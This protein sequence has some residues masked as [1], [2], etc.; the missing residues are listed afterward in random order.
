VRGA[1]FL[2]VLAAC[3]PDETN[4]AFLCGGDAD[5][6][7]GQAC[8]GGRCRRG[9]GGDGVLCMTET[10]DADHMCCI[11]GINAPRC[12]PAGDACAGDAAMC[13][14]V[15]DCT[16]GDRCCIDHITRC[17][18]SCAGDVACLSAADCPSALPNCCP[19]DLPWG[20]CFESPC[21]I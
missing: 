20:T 16:A 21:N 9:D 13:D 1:V 17:E 8:T 5:C 2:L 10:C 3:T 4:T 6:P 12:I 15:E 7:G 14:G 11:D 19:S 18:S